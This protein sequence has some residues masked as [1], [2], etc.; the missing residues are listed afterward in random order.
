MSYYGLSL[1]IG[2]L[3][4]DLFVNTIISGALE[5]PSVLLIIVVFTYAGRIPSFSGAMFLGAAGFLS[6]MTLQNSM[7]HTLL[8]IKVIIKGPLRNR[9]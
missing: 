6:S 5:I 3:G 9:A 1:N 7:Y 4:G 2:E 8:H